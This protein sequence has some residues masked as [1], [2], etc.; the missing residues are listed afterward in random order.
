MAKTY[1]SAMNIFVSLCAFVW[2]LF[3]EDCIKG[4]AH[5]AL[6]RSSR[7]RQMLCVHF[8]NNRR[9]GFPIGTLRISDGGLDETRGNTT[10]LTLNWARHSCLPL[11][12]GSNLLR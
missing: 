6:V 7:S 5:F 12:K 1:R 3:S 2:F 11:G 10:M 4:T 9:Q 8:G